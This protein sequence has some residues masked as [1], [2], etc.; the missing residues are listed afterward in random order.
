MFHPLAFTKTFALIGTA[1]ISITLV[2][3]L[4]PLLLRGRLSREEDN[5]IVRS[6]HRDVPAGAA[7]LLHE[8]PQDGHL[9]VRLPAGA[10][11][12]LLPRHLGR[13]FMPPLDEGSI[14][15]M[16]VT[17]PRAS[18]TKAGRRPQGARRDDARRSPRSRWSSARRGAPT[19]R[20]IPSPLDMVETIITCAR[21]ALAQAQAALRRRL[22][23]ER[24]ASLD[25]SAANGPA[26]SRPF[27][28]ED[29]ARRF[30][31]QCGQWRADALRRRDAARG[32]AAPAWTFEEELAPRLGRACSAQRLFCRRS[33]VGTMAGP[34]R[35]AEEN[36]QASMN[37]A[38][39]AHAAD[40]RTAPLLSTW[41]RCGRHDPRRACSSRAAHRLADSRR[42]ARDGGFAPRV[43]LAPMRRRRLAS[44]EG[45]VFQRA[46][47]RPRRTSGT[48]E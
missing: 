37:Y 16:P 40:F 6:V 8:P 13:E 26:R 10:R 18:V 34:S 28:T 33:R 41:S 43:L 2:P 24:T 45:D 9:A 3:A 22:R 25:A 20:P 29:A 39:A 11:A 23:R 17:V 12:V 32:D 5:W 21:G 4:I 48:S 31:Q 38:V 47:G 7:W 36:A 42:P 15:D 35:L 19:R 44:S 14:L 1:I 46:H 27:E 30:L